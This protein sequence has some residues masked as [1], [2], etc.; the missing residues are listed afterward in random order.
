MTQPNDNGTAAR[1]IE[2]VSTEVANRLTGLGIALDGKESP[3]DLV[4][5]QEAVE[6]FERA[7]QSRGGDLM[8]DEPPQPGSAQPDNSRF[9]LPLRTEG[10]SVEHYVERL[11][12]STNDILSQRARSD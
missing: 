3:G 7:V 4:T 6:R 10:E 5:I 2:R 9:G 1:D 12:R 11:I 8:V